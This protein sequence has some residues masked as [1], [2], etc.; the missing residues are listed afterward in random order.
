MRYRLLLSIAVLALGSTAC[1]EWRYE[2]AGFQLPRT[3]DV[4]HGKQAFVELGCNSCHK[5]VGS[6]LQGPTQPVAFTVNLGGDTSRRLSDAYLL[7]SI[8]NPDYHLTPNVKGE[9]TANGHSR[10]PAFTDKMTTRQ[11]VDVIAYLQ[12][13]YIVHRFT[14]NYTFQ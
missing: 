6:D 7:T 3:G 2:K 1:T 4:A 9:I 5:V 10:M 14:P 8:L 12:T 11:L 13:T